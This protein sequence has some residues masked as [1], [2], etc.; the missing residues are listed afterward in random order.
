MREDI[1]NRLTGAVRQFRHNSDNSP[2]THNPREGFVFGYDREEVDELIGDLLSELEAARAQQSG[3]GREAVAYVCHSCG[4]EAPPPAPFSLSVKCP[5]GH[6]TAATVAADLA[7]RAKAQ[8]VP[9]G[10][11]VW[12]TNGS[13]GNDMVV[14]HPDGKPRRFFN[15]RTE[16]LMFEFLRLLT[17]APPADTPEG[18]WVKCSERLPTE[19][20]VDFEYRLWCWFPERGDM[21]LLLLGQI[22]QAHMSGIAVLWTT[23]NLKRPAAPDIGGEK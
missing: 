12:E 9:E 4:N 19:D 17:K 22:I 3:E 14:E 2:D 1:K 10:W 13:I 18:E 21:K 23:T 11:K 16:P 8:G 20:D 6:S 15:R 7:K 5:C